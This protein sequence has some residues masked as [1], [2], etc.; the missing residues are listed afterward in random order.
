MV[1]K[2][3]IKFTQTELS[4]LARKPVWMTSVVCVARITS[5]AGFSAAALPSPD[6][7]SFS[8]E[9]SLHGFFLAFSLI[10]SSAQ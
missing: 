1:E 7:D 4:K 5:V 10:P 8:D 3:T 2:F 6:N 9:L